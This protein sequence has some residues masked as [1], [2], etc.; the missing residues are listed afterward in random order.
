MSKRPL[1]SNGAPLSY[2]A[3]T[4][5]CRIGPRFSVLFFSVMSILLVF[6]YVKRT[7]VAGPGIG[8]KAHF[9]VTLG[10]P[11]TFSRAAEVAMFFFFFFFFQLFSSF[12]FGFS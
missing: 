9:Y 8:L 7:L 11:A 4:S 1:Q 3:K 5:D 10:S 6:G 12:H 2:L